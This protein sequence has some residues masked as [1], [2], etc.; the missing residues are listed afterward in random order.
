MLFAIKDNKDNI[1]YQGESKKRTTI[2]ISIEG[3]ELVKRKKINLSKLC[4]DFL[5]YQLS[6]PNSA[7]KLEEK[8]EETRQK[9]TILER[10]LFNI[11]EKHK[12][13]LEIKE[14]EEKKAKFEALLKHFKA[15]LRVGKSNKL[16]IDRVIDLFGFDREKAVKCLENGTI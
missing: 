16:V 1:S 7:N 3:Y 12:R 15:N 9:L 8:I 13:A 11:K 6:A 5:T 4:N 10:K 2:Y 14:L